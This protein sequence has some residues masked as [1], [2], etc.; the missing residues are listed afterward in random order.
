MSLLELGGKQQSF[1]MWSEELLLPA[2]GA[3]GA[4]ISREYEG[5][6]YMLKLGQGDMSWKLYCDILNYILIHDVNLNT[7]KSPQKLFINARTRDRIEHHN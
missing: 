3:V 4:M 1:S 2:G 5:S 6:V 7:F